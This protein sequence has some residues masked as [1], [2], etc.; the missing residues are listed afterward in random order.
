MKSSVKNAPS[1]A[2]Q[3]C[4]A[5]QL[6][7]F[8]RGDID[9]Y[10]QLFLNNVG[11]TLVVAALLKTNYDPRNN[12]SY[13]K[14]YMTLFSTYPDLQSAN[15][16]AIS[17]YVFT[18]TVVGLA[19]SLAFGSIYYTWMA[20]RIARKVNVAPTALPFGV[21][22]PAA[23]AFS[24]SILIPI[25]SSE[26][27]TCY[28]KY[29]T[30]ADINVLSTCI[31]N[32]IN[33]SWSQGV[34]SNFVAGFLG[35]LMSFGGDFIMR[36]TP[37]VALLSSLATIGIAFLLLG[38]ISL[39]FADPITGLLPVGL[40]ILGY[41]C[42]V[43]YWVIPTT[44]MVVLVGTA[45]SWATG[46]S[47]YSDLEETFRQVG[48]TGASLGVSAL[49]DWSPVA[50]YFGTIFPFAIQA[51]VGTLM[52]V[53]SASKVGDRFPVKEAMVADGL[54]SMIGAIFGTPMMSSVYIGHPGFKAM[55]ATT[56]YTLINGASFLVFALFGLFAFINGLFPPGAL[57]PVITFIGFIICAEAMNGLP[58][59]HNMVFIAGLLPGICLWATE[60]NMKA[61]GNAQWGYVAMGGPNAMFFAMVLCSIL[62]YSTD[63]NFFMAG[64]WLLF[65]AFCAAIGLIHQDTVNFTDFATPH[66]TYCTNLYSSPGVIN[67]NAFIYAYNNHTGTVVCN[68]GYVVCNGGEG[69]GFETTTQWR[70][71]TS[72]F[73]LFAVYVVLYFFQ[74]TGKFPGIAP[75]EENDEDGPQD[76]HINSTIGKGVAK[77]LK[78]SC[79]T[80]VKHSDATMV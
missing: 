78:Q 63:R 21:N 41:F 45:L 51:A 17:D 76:D 4:T 40:M 53:S 36:T 16:A 11:T 5:W 3:A 18:R 34:L 62:A 13:N 57:A 30:E 39:N 7:S 32:G 69:C 47:K 19:L 74:R 6:I 2:K 72:Y 26:F 22:T 50:T 49:S 38:Q 66:G 1:S 64:L 23:F 71:M 73:M 12:S 33:S 52:N 46:Q 75:V 43:K 55:G 61:Y 25:A 24:Y 8:R 60:N 79:D 20:L 68:D 56:S 44:V 42:G 54:C 80:S 10:T 70:F 59:R 58:S 15:T 35:L 67:S 65:A 77:S 48:W 9:A 37:R 28:Q 31:T 29:Q 14:E 27:D